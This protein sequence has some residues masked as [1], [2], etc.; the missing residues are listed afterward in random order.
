VRICFVGLD[1]YPVLNPAYGG[2]YFGGESVQQTL[3]ARAFRASGHDVSMVVKDHG[4]PQADAVDGI[5]VYKSYQEQAGVPV[6]R[7]LHPRLTSIVQAL[8]MADADVYYQSCAGMLTGVTAWF[9]R[10]HGRR[11]VF[12]VA[13]DTDCIPGQHLINLWRDV[14]LYEYGLRRADF[15]AAQGEHQQ[16]LL[17]EHYQLS[18][19]VINMA[20]EPPAQAPVPG[21]GDIDVLWVNN[22]RDF[23]RPDLVVELARLV[24]EVNITMIGGAVPGNDAL[25]ARI[26]EQA[27]S[28]PNLDF[29]GA[30][31]Y[32]EV[33]GYFDRSRIFINTSD[34]EGFP[35]S[36]LQAWIRAV[37]VVSFFDPDGLIAQ[38]GLGAAPTDVGDMARLLSAWLGQPTLLEEHAR[39]ARDFAL[40][41]YAP[42]AVAQRYV[43]LGALPPAEG[44]TA[45]ATSGA[46]GRGT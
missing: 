21:H 15:I 4:Q 26:K 35:N 12:R 37:P 22:L 10:R 36:F 8:R 16:R 25:Y 28:L 41:R 24:P 44:V 3:L 6:L 33:N 27:A 39:R 32:A 42:D 38:H 5:T 13:H 34:S 40:A 20:V 17:E 23:K 30:V 18:S 29:L 46:S 14:K 19:H 9:C 1:N 31:P 45:L 11:L 2:E 43:D 7:F